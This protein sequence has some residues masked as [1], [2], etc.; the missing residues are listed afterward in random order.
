MSC[1]C[2]LGRATIRATAVPQALLAFLLFPVSSRRLHG[3]PLHY[4]L[5]CSTVQYG[6]T[7][8]QR[9]H[10]RRARGNVAA[11]RCWRG[12]RGE[13]SHPCCDQR[14][15]SQAFLTFLPGDDDHVRCTP[16]D[17]LTLTHLDN[18]LHFESLLQTLPP[19]VS[20]HSLHTTSALVSSDLWLATVQVSARETRTIPL[21]PLN[22]DTTYCNNA[23]TPSPPSTSSPP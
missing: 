20:A 19:H 23:Q 10:V 11:S 9:F 16:L 1:S 22:P 2:W 17:N 13:P 15:P 4:L 8:S 5:Q 21:T 6:D 18:T 3:C 14:E 7:N 12:G